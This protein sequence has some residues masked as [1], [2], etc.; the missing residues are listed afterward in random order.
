MVRAGET[1]E[2]ITIKVEIVVTQNPNVMK[3]RWGWCDKFISVKRPSIYY[4]HLYRCKAKRLEE[5]MTDPK[6]HREKFKLEKKEAA[7]QRRI[8]NKEEWDR[9]NK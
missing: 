4:H 1:V 3:C 9:Q 6:Y 2:E 8:K 5:I 7:K